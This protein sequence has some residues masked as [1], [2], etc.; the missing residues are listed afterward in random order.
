[1]YAEI[2]E[3]ALGDVAQIPVWYQPYQHVY[4]PSV[5]NLHMNPAIQWNL[6]EAWVDAGQG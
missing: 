2:Q 3:I 1:M 5:R 6:D 4:G